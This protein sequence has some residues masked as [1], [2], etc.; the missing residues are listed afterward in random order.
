MI[1]SASGTGEGT[2]S[3]NISWQKIVKS[4]VE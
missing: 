4:W 2:F 1:L 3:S